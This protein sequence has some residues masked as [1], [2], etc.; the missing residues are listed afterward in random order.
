VVVV[1][2][3]PSERWER[4]GTPQETQQSGHAAWSGPEVKN[5]RSGAEDG[6]PV[7]LGCGTVKEEVRWSSVWELRSRRLEPLL[8]F[9]KPLLHHLIPLTLKFFLLIVIARMLHVSI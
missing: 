1:Y 9:V 8:E 3:Y 6:A 5:R 7:R 4:G 2:P